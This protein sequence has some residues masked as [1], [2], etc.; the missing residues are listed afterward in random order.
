MNLPGAQVMI[1][2]AAASAAMHAYL[3][4]FLRIN[5]KGHGLGVASLP[6]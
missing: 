6:G 4:I 1:A 2:N 3:A 5:G